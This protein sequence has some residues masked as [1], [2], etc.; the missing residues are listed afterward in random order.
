[1]SIKCHCS[2]AAMPASLMRAVRRGPIAPNPHGIVEIAIPSLRC[3][4]ARDVGSRTNNQAA[5]Y[6]YETWLPSSGE[7]LSGHPLIFHYVNVGPNV[8]AHEAI[9]DVYMPIL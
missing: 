2:A 1:M 3:A 5:R 4:L 8:Q 6:L 7:K 9:T